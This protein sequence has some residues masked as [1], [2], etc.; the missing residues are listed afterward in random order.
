MH[1]KWQLCLDWLFNPSKKQKRKQNKTK[2]KQQQQQQQQ[3]IST[4]KGIII[5]GTPSQMV[6]SLN[7][8]TRT[9]IVNYAS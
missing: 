2:K 8:F 6:T 3:K 1:I 4:T 7:V 5:Q 9:Q